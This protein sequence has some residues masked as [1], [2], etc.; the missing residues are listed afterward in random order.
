MLSR[1][2]PSDAPRVVARQRELTV[3]R[4]SIRTRLP[5][6]PVEA[7]KR[8]PRD[9]AWHSLPQGRARRLPPPDSSGEECRHRRTSGWRR[10]QWRRS[11]NRHR[12]ETPSE[13]DRWDLSSAVDGTSR[14]SA[15][16][17][18]D[19]RATGVPGADVNPPY[20]MAVI[21]AAVSRHI[22]SADGAG[23]DFSAL[24]GKFRA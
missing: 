13:E 2:G 10:F 6:P 21:P 14:C 18:C 24:G 17:Y 22:V 9:A 15:F 5:I 8:F 7:V 12:D 23:R 4:A 20:A 19:G 16:S 3:R 11:A 1:G